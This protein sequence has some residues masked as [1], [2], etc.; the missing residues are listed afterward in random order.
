MQHLT[1][2]NYQAPNTREDE[3]AVLVPVTSS[4][5]QSL[6]SRVPGWWHIFRVDEFITSFSGFGQTIF[7]NVLS[8]PIKQLEFVSNKKTTITIITHT[9]AGFS[10]TAVNWYRLHS[11][12]RSRPD[13]FVVYLV[14]YA[15]CFGMAKLQ[16][17]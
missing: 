17:K 8:G 11:A 9:L 13:S 10:N 3:S 1:P 12:N 6:Y 4:D 16:T 7:S 14:S 2:Y 5:K 15:C